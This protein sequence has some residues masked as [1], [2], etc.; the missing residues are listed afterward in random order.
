MQETS[1]LLLL[2]DTSQAVLQL[3][4]AHGTRHRDTPRHNAAIA[5]RPRAPTERC[6]IHS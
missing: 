4:R 5:H 2:P 1:A 6:I 3:T